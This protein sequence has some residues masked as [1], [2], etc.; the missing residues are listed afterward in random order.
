MGH[1]HPAAFTVV[2]ISLDYC[3]QHAMQQLFW[4]QWFPL[5]RV[6]PIKNG[7]WSQITSFRVW[8]FHLC[9]VLSFRK[10]LNLYVN[11]EVE[12][13]VPTSESCWQDWM[14]YMWDLK[15]AAWHTTSAQHSLLLLYS[16][17]KSGMCQ[18]G[19]ANCFLKKLICIL[20]LSI[21][22]KNDLFA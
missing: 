3:F 10:L 20:R 12:M 19:C 21:W 6:E 9:F 4:F 5:I 15:T 1:V 2:C 7:L 18:K 13:I 14:K 11:C 16:S 8:P 22:Q 17:T